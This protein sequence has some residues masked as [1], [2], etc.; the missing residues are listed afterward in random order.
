MKTDIYRTLETMIQRYDE[1][2]VCRQQIVEA[3]LLLSKCFHNDKKLIV[4][5]NGGS[6]ADSEHIVGELMKSFRIPRPINRMYQTKLK[7]SFENGEYLANKLQRALPALSL[8]GGISLIS[9]LTNDV[10]ADM[11]FAQQVFGIGCIDDVLL[12]IS[13]SGNS[14]NVV[15]ALKIAKSLGIHTIG[16]TGRTG[17]EM[18]SFCDVTICVPQIDTFLVQELHLPIYHTLC[19]MLEQEFFE[20][21]TDQ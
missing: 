13:T 12:G 1:L 6:A 17:G 14:E 11:I 20:K 4:C 5:G 10:A 3:Y 21:T 15:N 2:N 8:T 9:A 19:A 18:S 7:E 16:L